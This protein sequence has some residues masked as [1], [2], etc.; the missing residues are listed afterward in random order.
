MSE[1]PAR[2]RW[3]ERDRQRLP[4]DRIRSR[5]QGRRLDVPL[6]VELTDMSE[7]E[8]M[9]AMDIENRHRGIESV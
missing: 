3:N 5:Q 9:V 7:K 1:F 6:R 4:A 8:A 2:S